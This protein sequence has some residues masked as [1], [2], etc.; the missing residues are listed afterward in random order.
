M[1]KGEI[2]KKINYKKDTRNHQ[3]QLINLVTGVIRLG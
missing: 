3:N 1:L 2:K